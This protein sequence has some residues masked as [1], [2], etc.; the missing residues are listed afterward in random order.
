LT[1]RKVFVGREALT[2]NRDNERN[3]SKHSIHYRKRRIR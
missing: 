2:N 1:D 3:P